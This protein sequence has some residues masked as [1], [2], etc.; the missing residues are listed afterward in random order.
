M[1][2]DNELLNSIRHFRE[3]NK[4]A[5]RNTIAKHF[6]ITSYKARTYIDFIKYSNTNVK[7]EHC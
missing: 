3:H 5:G 2:I 7:D 1:A 6:N 4:N